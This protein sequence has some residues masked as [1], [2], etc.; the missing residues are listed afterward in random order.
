[1]EGVGKR[2]I[3]RSRLQEVVAVYFR[4]LVRS[5]HSHSSLSSVGWWRGG[6]GHCEVEIVTA[7]EKGGDEGHVVGKSKVG[8][9]PRFADKSFG[10]PASTTL[11]AQT[12]NGEEVHW[13]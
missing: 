8:I 12:R 4:A 9:Y 10:Y 3:I 13:G 6:S 1:M 11:I 7:F 2:S 5:L